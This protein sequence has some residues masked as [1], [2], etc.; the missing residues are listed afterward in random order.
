VTD[1]TRPTNADAATEAA[2]TDALAAT[3]ATGATDAAGTTGPPEDTRDLTDREMGL[4]R[5]TGHDFGPCYLARPYPRRTMLHVLAEQAERRGDHDWLVFDA[6]QRLT[7]AQAWA[8]TCQVADALRRRVGTG[9]HVGLL[10]RN[11]PSFLPT[12]YGAMLAPGVA[13][14]LNADARGP[15]LEY[16]IEQ[17]DCTVLVVRADLVERLEQLQDLHDVELIV[18]VGD[19]RAVP[20]RVLGVETITESALLEG[21]SDAPVPLADL[22]VHASELCMLMFTS[23]TTGRAKGAMYSHHFLYLYSATVTDS[24]ER[25]P[26]DVL[27]TPL[28]LYHSAAMHLIANSAMH[29]GATAHLKSRF[30]A[31]RFWQQVADDGAT[32]G[33][34]LGPMAAMVLKSTDEVP[35]HR[36]DH[37]WCVPPIQKDE[38]EARFGVRVVWQGYG[39]TEVEPMPMRKHMLPDVP[40]DTLGHVA[41][42]MDWG[43]VDEDDRL[44][45]PGERG[46]LVLRCLVPHGMADGYYGRP[47]ATAEAFRNFRFHTGDLASYDQDGL[48]HFHGRMQERIRRRGENISA[49]EVEFVVLTHPEVLEAAV[50]GVPSELGE[51]DVKLDVVTR[52]AAEPDGFEDWL[53]TNLPRF[54]VPRFVEVRQSFPKTPSE[55]IQKHLLAEEALDRPTVRDLEAAAAAARG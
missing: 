48:L 35:E 17:A 19:D 43:V 16:V 15:L 54:M 40:I 21:A 23:G 5:G 36:M 28:P 49:P 26:D 8:R 33:I 29:V 20:D 12:F 22:D 31:T 27:T 55:R 24:L 34:I 41:R 32:G 14:P 1:A 3:G 38:F 30:S 13:V 46:E 18:V 51:H 44:L 53:R 4:Y 25:T 42:W 45:P 2:A 52:T 11:Q 9:A 47:D 39:M 37:L 10:L 6:Q 7:Y 50:Y